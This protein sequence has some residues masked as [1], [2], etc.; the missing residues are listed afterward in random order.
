M[1]KAAGEMLGFFSELGFCFPQFPYIAHTRGWSAEDM[2][3]NI[4]QVQK[5]EELR[6]AAR[7]LADRAVD[8]SR[9][10]L[11]HAAEAGRMPRGGRKAHLLDVETEER[12]MMTAGMAVKP[13]A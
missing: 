7:G 4:A 10:L 8:L 9:M 1:C 12:A 3:R 6:Q 11:E 2:E 5:S 13:S